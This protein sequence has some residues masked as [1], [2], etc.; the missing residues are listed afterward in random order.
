MQA[1]NNQTQ[2]LHCQD[3]TSREK[4]MPI[5]LPHAGKCFENVDKVSGK[6]VR[7]RLRARSRRGEKKKCT[8]G[9]GA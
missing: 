4:K 3:I 2:K 6:Y 8:Q 7:S 1:T 9:F 5:N